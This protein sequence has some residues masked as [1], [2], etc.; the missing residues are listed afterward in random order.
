LTPLVEANQEENILDAFGM[1]NVMYDG[2]TIALIMIIPH[3]GT[4][5]PNV[6]RG[7]FNPKAIGIATVTAIKARLE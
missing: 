4:K 7:R 6:F 3:T 1:I 5:E 2:I